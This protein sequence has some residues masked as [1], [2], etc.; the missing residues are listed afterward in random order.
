MSV[1]HA[2]A[3]MGALCLGKSLVE[4]FVLGLFNFQCRIMVLILKGALC[5]DSL[6]LLQW[7]VTG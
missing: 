1:S 2:P 5:F 4:L 3:A 7:M 6:P